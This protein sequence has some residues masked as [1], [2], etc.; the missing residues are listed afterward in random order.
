M[1]GLIVPSACGVV[2]STNYLG[3]EFRSC[4]ATLIRR[5]GRVVAQSSQNYVHT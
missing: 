3:Y 4:I 5:G 2:R 1:Q